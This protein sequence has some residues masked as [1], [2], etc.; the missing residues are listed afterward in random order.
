MS[1][2][3]YIP[4]SSVFLVL[5]LVGV[6]ACHGMEGGRQDT[7]T[8]AVY[9]QLV[10]KQIE[11]AC[12]KEKGFGGGFTSKRERDHAFAIISCAFESLTKADADSLFPK[13]MDELRKKRFELDNFWKQMLNPI[14]DSGYP[15]N[16]YALFPG[17]TGVGGAYPWKVPTEYAN[18]AERTQKLGCGA[19]RCY[20]C[21]SC[22]S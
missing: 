9:I 20:N 4:M 6:F 2:K 13:A 19:S 11:A 12:A 16:V 14:F 7:V 3:S 17:E 18:D 5:N 15:M 1:L 22:M 10:T 21:T 8:V